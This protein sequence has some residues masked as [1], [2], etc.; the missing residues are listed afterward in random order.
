MSSKTTKTKL[1][2]TQSNR[3]TRASLCLSKK[4]KFLLLKNNW[5]L[6]RLLSPQTQSKSPLSSKFSSY[7]KFHLFLMYLTLLEL[8]K[9]KAK[10][11]KVKLPAIKKK[12]RE[13]IKS[14]ASANVNAERETK[15]LRSKANL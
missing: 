3:P 15:N 9:I 10:L 4:K 6:R 8:S 7:S 12:L 5:L 2:K 11:K 1:W 13:I 14:L